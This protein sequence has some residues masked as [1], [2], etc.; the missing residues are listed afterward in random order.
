LQYET[1]PP[2]G[3]SGGNRQ[4]RDRTVAEVL[5]EGLLAGAFTL[6]VLRP[7][8]ETAERNRYA[9]P[10]NALALGLAVF[11]VVHIARV[12][13]SRAVS[14]DFAHYYIS[15][16]LL[17]TGADVYSTPLEPEYDRWGFHYT[18]GIPTATNPPFLI[19]VFAPFA[20][21][22]P[23]AAFWAWTLLET[24]C[25][26]YVLVQTWQLTSSR[27]SAPAQMLV[28][29]AIMA[30]APVYWHFFFSQCQL[31]I[32]A[33]ILVA[34]RFLRNGKPQR[35]CLV[36]AT[37]GWLKIFP[38]V[39]L[40]W[41]L[42]RASADWKMRWK[43]LGATF[44][45]SIGIVL[46]TGWEC[47]KQFWTHGMAV[48]ERWVT[49]QR[50]FNFTAP[51]FV[52]NAA[53]SV[54]GFN[55]EWNRLHGWVTIGAVIGLALIALAYGLSWRTGGRQKGVDL[56][57]EFCLLSVAMLAGITEAWGHY[58]VILGFPAA[59][60]VARIVQRPTCGRAVILGASLVML[61]AMGSWR[62]PWLEFVVSYIPLYGLLLLGAFFVNEM[63]CSAPLTA[64]PTTFV[65][66]RS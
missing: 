7:D 45:W 26:A 58:F 36:I 17:L 3:T 62:S 40:P 51:S 61:N 9:W 8:A 57:L 52:K 49:W 21:L 50:H 14:N 31:L 56:E 29:G 33:M 30:S 43:C 55:P 10:L 63:R 22:P 5:P 28:C 47:W 11:G 25:L 60:G 1:I 46:A 59:V 44:A 19:G 38:V 65:P 15:S 64:S 54:H 12:L 37:A 41:F 18:R 27:L 23:R 34:Y 48:L 4:A 35:A 32:A 66:Q 2:R 6:Q 53:W 20:A 39:L 13:P 42:W 24:V 16:R